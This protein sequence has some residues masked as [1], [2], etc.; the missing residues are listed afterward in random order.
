MDSGFAVLDDFNFTFESK[1][2][3]QHFCLSFFIFVT[4]L[5]TTV[6]DYSAFDLQ[7]KLNC[8]KV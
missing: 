3:S 6:I 8:R 4:T 1:I 2:K 7:K 5:L